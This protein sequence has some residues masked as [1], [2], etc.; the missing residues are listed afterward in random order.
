MNRHVKRYLTITAGTCVSGIAMNAF[1]LPNHLLS[2]GVTGLGMILYYL[3]GWPV[4]ITNLLFNIPLFILAYKLMSREYFLS[5]VYGTVALSFWIRTFSFLK[6]YVPVDDPMLCSIAAGVLH[7]IGLGTLYRVGGSTGGTDI[8]GGIMQKFY[9]ISIGTT[10][11][12]INLCLLSIEAYCFGLAPA[13]YTIVAYFAVAK[14]SNAF[15]DGFDYKKNVFII[16]DKSEAIAE[17]IIEKLGR[18][19][20]YMEGEGA[21]THERRQVLFCV[22]KLTQVARLK[23]LVVQNDPDAFMIV[24]DAKDVLGRGFTREKNHNI[25]RP[26]E[27]S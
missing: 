7:G 25:K 8:I 9:S 2:G 12:L 6:G 10:G 3:F 22:V 18:G 1:F 26:M 21:Y 13:M 17:A 4:D 5:G 15:A 19:A 20:T 27:M 14:M 24:Q 23:E 11:F 16:S